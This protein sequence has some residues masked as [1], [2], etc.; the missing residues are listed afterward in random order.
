MHP[1]LQVTEVLS[2]IAREVDL[3]RDHLSMA[4]TCKCFYE[5]AIKMLWAECVSWRQLLACFPE[6]VWHISKENKLEGPSRPPTRTE[7]DRVLAHFRHVQT[8]NMYMAPY[9]DLVV[10]LRFLSNYRPVTKLFPQLKHLLCL[11]IEEMAEFIGMLAGPSLR[12]AAISAS[13]RHLAFALQISA[14][15]SP[16]LRVLHICPE[17]QHSVYS[18]T[19]RAFHRCGHLFKNLLYL[20]CKGVLSFSPSMFLG[21]SARLPHL[22]NLECDIEPLEDEYTPPTQPHFPDLHSLDIHTASVPQ[23]IVDLLQTQGMQE[24]EKMRITFT[25]QPSLRSVRKLFKVLGKHKAIQSLK[26]SIDEAPEVHD[27][28]ITI[29]EPVIRLLFGCETL[30]EVQMSNFVCSLQD[31]SLEAMATAWPQLKTLEI[32]QTRSQTPGKITFRGLYALT[33]RFPQ[34]R[35]IGLPFNFAAVSEEDLTYG[36][37][38]PSLSLSDIIVDSM[39]TIPDQALL[40]VVT[41]ALFPN[42]RFLPSHPDAPHSPWPDI[43]RML[44]LH[45][46]ART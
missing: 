20:S 22:R 2:L 15:E 12:L 34:L 27:P 3:P 26:F 25:N 8:I 13:D 1:C 10:Y 38:A 9:D 32:M 7:W 39:P 42:A 45:K 11:L 37:H 29:S 36:K 16:L 14:D 23:V 46:L 17:M 41:S 4:L 43:N 28:A 33:S 19:S 44:R 21:L 18:V 5:P 31:N 30:Q 35:S 40:A 24:L 6:D